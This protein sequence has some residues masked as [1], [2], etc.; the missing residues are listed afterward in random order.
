[1]ADID[2]RWLL[3][4]D[5]DDD[6]E[7]EEEEQ[8]ED[9]GPRPVTEKLLEHR[10]I[11]L[12]EPISAE[13]AND[14]VAR[15]LVLDAEDSE[16]PINIYINSP[17]GS[18]DAG[19]AIFDMIRFVE[20]PVRCIA[21]GLCASAAVII[22]LGA[23]KENRLALPNSRFLIHQPSGGAHGSTTDIE[24]EANEI[25]KIRRRINKLIAEETGK[26][27]DEIADATK[28]NY[29]LNAEESVGYGLVTRILGSKKD[30]Q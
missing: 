23:Q 26:P 10:T 24:I 9:L 21:N 27:E 19:Y 18:V 2:P 11:L 3:N 4:D 20:A 1:M 30:L 25:L 15:L 5:D 14:V 28:R 7:E 29:W 6:D 22:L 13:L 16:A 8:R 17:G 12:T